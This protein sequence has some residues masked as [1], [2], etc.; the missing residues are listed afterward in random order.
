M[1]DR[2]LLIEGWSVEPDV[3]VDNLPWETFGGRDRQLEAAV[4]ELLVR[5]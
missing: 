2:K 5:I 4:T 3:V 1:T